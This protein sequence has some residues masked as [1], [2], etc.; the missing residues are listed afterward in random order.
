MKLARSAL[1]LFLFYTG[2]FVQMVFWTPVYFFMPRKECWKVVRLWALG[3]LWLQYWIV[4]TRFD[5]RGIE[6]LE[7]DSGFILASKHQ[8]TWET[9]ATLLFVRDP[10][11]ILKRELMFVPFFGWFATK[12]QV[13]AVNRGKRSEALRQ[14]NNM[15]REQLDDGR[16][17]VIYPEGTRRLAF[18]EPAYK[19]GVTH[20]YNSIGAAV[21][22]AGTNSGVFWPR[23][24]LQ[25]YRGTCVIE[26]LPIIEPGLDAD[27]FSERLQSDIEGSTSALLDE[28]MQDPE[29]DGKSRF[30]EHAAS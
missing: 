9:Y 6:N 30:A 1:F 23:N 27:T 26:F 22:P 18:A 19:Y 17:I 20:M 3:N 25:L 4:G 8:S 21:L 13:I 15:A 16:Q 29:F 10:S 11:Y 7:T 5:F 14:M 2:T 12:A 24:A 28:A